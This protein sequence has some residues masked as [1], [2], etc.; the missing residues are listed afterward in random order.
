[1]AGCDYLTSPKGIAF[2]TA[3]GHFQKHRTLKNVFDFFMNNKKGLIDQTYIKHFYRAYLTFRYQRVYCPVKRQIVYLN[4]FPADLEF[5]NSNLKSV[6]NLDFQKLKNFNA[7]MIKYNDLELLKYFLKED[8]ELQFLG[9]H[10]DDR[11]GQ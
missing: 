8:P 4:E 6:K 2:K 3:Y 9:P 10:L 11:T 1:L 7:E 5:D